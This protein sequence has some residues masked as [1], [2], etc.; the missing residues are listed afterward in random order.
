MCVCV[1]V[2][3]SSEDLMF[4]LPTVSLFDGE[5]HQSLEQKKR[6]KRKKKQ[7]SSHILEN[8]DLQMFQS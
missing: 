2:C 7:K 3:V 4:Y 5:S 6:K 1:C 8:C